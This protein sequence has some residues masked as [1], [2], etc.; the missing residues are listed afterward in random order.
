M[1]INT[2]REGHY[3]IG[4]LVTLAW[5]AEGTLETSDPITFHAEPGLKT[6]VLELLG[7]R[8][9]QCVENRGTCVY[10]A[11]ENEMKDR[12][13]KP[14]IDYLREFLGLEPPAARPTVRV[15]A[16]DMEWAKTT[17]A[18]LGGDDLVLVF[19]QTKWVPQDW[20]ACYWNDLGWQLVE[21]N[22][23][24]LVMLSHEDKRYA[25]M[26]LFYWGFSLPCVASLMSLASLVVTVD[27]GPAHLAGTMGVPTIA[28]TGPTRPRCAFAHLPEVVAL[29]SHIDPDCA[30]CQYQAPFRPAC[31][32]GCQ[33]LYGLR[34]HQVLAKIV[35]ELAL[36]RRGPR[37]PLSFAVKEDH[38]T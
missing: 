38:A 9:M 37:K 7:Q 10:P 5:I 33:M 20:P 17:R 26:P 25:N 32:S 31:D 19:P 12:G 4:D 6:G 22:V 23:K 8:V 36:L 35:S 16:N 27:N 29:T 28:L 3:G 18:N 21:R 2:D 11:F 34:P 1:R 24:C 15:S 14:R 13:R 30:G